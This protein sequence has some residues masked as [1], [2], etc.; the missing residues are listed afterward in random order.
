VPFVVP[1][2]PGG[3]SN[4]FCSAGVFIPARELAAAIVEQRRKSRQA[5]VPLLVPVD[6]RDWDALIPP[7]TPGTVRNLLDRLKLGG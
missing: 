2:S 4:P 3:S 6:T 1:G 7:D 5:A